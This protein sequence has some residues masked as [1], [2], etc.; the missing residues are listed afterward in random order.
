MNGIE[1]FKDIP[2]FYL[3]K[4]FSLIFF[5]SILIKILVFNN[6]DIYVILTTLS[7]IN[8]KMAVI[9]IILVYNF[10]LVIVICIYS[11]TAFFIGGFYYSSYFKFNFAYLFQI[12]LFSLLAFL[13]IFNAS[14]SFI[15]M[16]PV[17][18]SVMMISFVS[19][20][21]TSLFY[22]LQAPIQKN[23]HIR[24]FSFNIISIVILLRFIILMKKVIYIT[25][26]IYTHIYLFAI[27]NSLFTLLSS[28]IM[29]ILYLIDYEN[30]GNSVKIVQCCFNVQSLSIMMELILASALF[31]SFVV[32]DLHLSLFF[33]KNIS[34]Q[35]PLDH[36]T[37]ILKKSSNMHLSSIHYYMS[38][39]YYFSSN[40]N[41]VIEL[42]S[43]KFSFNLKSKNSPLSPTNLFS[44][45]E[46]MRKIPFVA[47][48][49]AFS[50]SNPSTTVP[51]VV[52]TDSD[53]FF[54]Y[55]LITS[56]IKSFRNSPNFF[57]YYIK[58]INSKT[59][60]DDTDLTKDEKNDNNEEVELTSDE[61]ED[62]TVQKVC[63]VEE[64]FF[65]FDKVKYRFT[66]VDEYNF[67]DQIQN[68]QKL[69]NNITNATNKQSSFLFINFFFYSNFV[70]NFS[71]K[72]SNSI[73]FDFEYFII[74]TVLAYVACRFIMLVFERKKFIESQKAYDY[75]TLLPNAST[76]DL[77]R[78]Q[79]TCI[80]CRN[81]MTTKTAKR[82]RC[83]H[84]IHLSCLIKWAKLRNR[85]PLCQEEVVMTQDGNGH[86][87]YFYNYNRKIFSYNIRKN[88]KNKNF[89]FLNDFTN[90]FTNS[91]ED[92]QNVSPYLLFYV[93]SLRKFRFLKRHLLILN[94][95][96][97]SNLSN[98]IQKRK[99]KLNNSDCNNEA[100]NFAVLNNGYHIDLNN[101]QISEMILNESPALWYFLNDFYYDNNDANRINN[102]DQVNNP[103]NNENENLNNNNNENN[104]D[105]R[106]DADDNE[107]NI[108]ENLINDNN[109]NNQNNTPLAN[110]GID[111][112]AGNYFI[113]QNRNSIAQLQ[114]I[115]ESNN[116]VFSMSRFI[117]KS[118][119]E[120]ENSEELAA[121]R[122]VSQYKSRFEFDYSLIIIVY[123]EMLNNF[124][125]LLKEESFI[126]N[127]QKELQK[128]R[129]VKQ[130]EIEENIQFASKI[131][132]LIKKYRAAFKEIEEQKPWT[133]FC[134]PFD[135]INC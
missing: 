61:Y 99:N 42:V 105:H 126:N 98:F 65:A 90:F 32:K 79:Y 41:A 76:V 130:E 89:I 94:R 97:S 1:N 39:V 11:Q 50:I 66:S 33:Q 132:L 103:I 52:S 9:D 120:R 7:D 60:N 72:R 4:L 15:F 16:F 92:E 117:D 20:F 127:Q 64:S 36:F 71:N 78:C 58:Q 24:L 46:E 40:A 6:F 53:P 19:H 2:F 70:N 93:C 22:Q 63:K 10:Y 17:L 14:K 106:N 18:L 116:E 30:F 27:I 13:N 96:C 88:R 81:K 119:D 133:K 34:V 82:L 129:G 57:R 111:N 51:L 75:L 115:N 100:D 47:K 122:L 59:Y 68:K 112:E 114:N 91:D 12:L 121:R 134:D 56:S 23:Y 104:N 74:I 29:H 3:Y 123:H 107:I 80:I 101:D 118:K 28:L 69:T 43:Q 108:N 77:V 49:S 26:D 35:V 102:I 85:C 38:S 124:S 62:D 44:L 5:F 48:I 128:I 109:G 113:N 45:F 86:Y 84:C 31:F 125:F 21:L 67:K 83:H 25:N 37:S 73:Y 110:N 87:S 54:N 131:S 8:S 135:E 55:F 95:K